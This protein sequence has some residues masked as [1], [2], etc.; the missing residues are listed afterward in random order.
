M[1]NERSERKNNPSPKESKRKLPPPV[2]LFRDIVVSDETTAN[3][4]PLQERAAYDI[5]TY[6]FRVPE[7]IKTCPYPGSRNGKDMNFSALQSLTNNY[8]EVIDGFGWINRLHFGDDIPQ[9]VTL[10]DF[11]E[12]SQ[13]GEALPSFAF[14]RAKNP[15]RKQY[16]LPDFIGDIFKSSRGLFAASDDMMRG[17]LFETEVTPSL[18]YSHVE[19]NHTLVGKD[20]VCAAPQKMIEQVISALLYRERA[21]PNDSRLNF[22]YSDNDKIEEYTDLY[23]SARD[24]TTDLAVA[25][26]GTWRTIVT[27]FS[28]RFTRDDKDR[29]LSLLTEFHEKED[30]LLWEANPL[31][32][33]MNQIL[34]R[35][36]QGIKP[37]TIADFKSIVP[38]DPFERAKALGLTD[39]ELKSIRRKKIYRR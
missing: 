31:Q 6:S 5:S 28:P 23:I 15:Y 4:R 37:I 2:S 12:M 19:E 30:E 32:E 13:I 25:A 9:K 38:F 10:T 3:G 7:E 39:E 21:N 14:N 27:D 17:H 16:H 18:I 36:Y 20:E 34:G 33:D 35:Q 26:I 11:W 8:K 22:I 1:G 24:I 29:I